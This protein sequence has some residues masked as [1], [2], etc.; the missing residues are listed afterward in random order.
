MRIG[1]DEGKLQIDALTGLAVRRW[2][3]KAF[4]TLEVWMLI[5]R[6]RLQQRDPQCVLRQPNRI[7]RS[8]HLKASAAV[9]LAGILHEQ[10]GC[11]P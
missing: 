5:P 3:S 7:I 11:S 2:T 4:E 8:A 1:T 10:E 9:E 6:R